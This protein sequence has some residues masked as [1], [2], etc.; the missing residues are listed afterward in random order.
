VPVISASYEIDRH[1]HFESGDSFAIEEFG[2]LTLVDLLSGNTELT[3]KM[4]YYPELPAWAFAN[5]WHNSI[6]MAYAD[7]YRPDTLSGPCS[8]GTDCLQIA[9][10]PGSPQDKVSLLVIAGEHLV[11]TGDPGLQDD[12]ITSVF[13]A[14]NAGDDTLFLLHQGN[15]EILVIKELP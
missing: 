6:R 7:D 8:V 4:I 11:D 5:D 9:D 10:A 1:L 3:L 12:D 15:D 2:D 13:D 14:D